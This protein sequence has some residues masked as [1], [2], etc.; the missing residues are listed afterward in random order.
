[1]TLRGLNSQYQK[2]VANTIAN[3]FAEGNVYQGEVCVEEKEKFYNYLHEVDRF[4][5]DS[6]VRFFKKVNENKI[7]T[8]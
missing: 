5:H 1:M 8:I 6:I 2:C 7:N 4:E 3:S